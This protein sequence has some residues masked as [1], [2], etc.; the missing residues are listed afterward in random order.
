[1]KKKAFLFITGLL[2]WAGSFTFLHAEKIR[3][4]GN[5]ITKE[6]QVSGFKSIVIGPGVE[7]NSRFFSKNTYQS[8]VLNYTQTTGAFAL[9]VT[10]DENL[11]SSL[12]I[13][14]D[15]NELSVRTSK[16]I[17]IN[18]SKLEIKANAKELKKVT[19][20]GCIDFVMANAFQSDRLDIAISGASDVKI[21]H[22]AQID[23]FTV[24]IRGAGNLIAEE[25]VCK[26]LETNISGAGDIMLKGKADKAGFR[27][28]GAG[29]IKAYD[30][31]VK[32][33]ECR[34]SGSGDA[35]IMATETLDATVSGAGDIRYKGNARANTRVSGFGNIKKVD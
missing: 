28:S 24:Q 2:L 1:M 17:V 33:L 14:S 7:C 10:M 35:K 34:V 9:S 15:G 26:E 8:P 16:G 31:I 21:N 30:F 12:E 20:S 25:L 6:I 13:K 4:N 5:V 32:N 19:I 27:V 3:G 11:F 29:D 22:S 23:Q 18:P